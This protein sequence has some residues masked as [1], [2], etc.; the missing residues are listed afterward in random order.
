MGRR[1]LDF[2]VTKAEYLRFKAAFEAGRICPTCPGAW[3]K[4]HPYRTV[5]E[6]GHRCAGCRRCVSPALR[7]AVLVDAGWRCHYCGSYADQVDHV[8][9]V[10]QGG[11]SR[12][13]NLAA[14]CRPCNA[15]KLDW[16]PEEWAAGEY[17]R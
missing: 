8:V 2:E 11:D 12:R 16:T 14:A 1:L 5:T 17:A 7:D 10:A 6:A 13:E 4:G 15:D 9:P 3:R